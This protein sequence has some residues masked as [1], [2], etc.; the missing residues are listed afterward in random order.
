MIVTWP[1]AAPAVAGSNCR[2]RVTDWLGFKVTGKV[3]PDMLKPVPVS[4]AE[5]TVTD[6]VPVEVRVKDWV[7]GV[8]ITTFPNAT[9]VALM[10]RID[11]PLVFN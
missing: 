7:A 4:V 8:L 1:V 6:A 10:L 11:V 3:A 2:F 9:L 5:F